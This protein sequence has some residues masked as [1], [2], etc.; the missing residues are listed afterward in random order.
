[1]Y[2]LEKKKEKKNERGCRGT[3]KDVLSL[4]LDRELYP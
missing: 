1:M 4:R 2:D 3:F